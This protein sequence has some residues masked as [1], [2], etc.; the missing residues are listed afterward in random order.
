MTDQLTADQATFPVDS[1]RDAAPHLRRP[2]ARSAVKFKIVGGNTVAAF[3]DA[4]LV[5]ERL[6]LVVPHLWFDEYETVPGGLLCKLT[7]DGISRIDIGTGYANNA[8]GLRSDSFKRAAVKF[9][10]GVSLY[11]IP[12]VAIDSQYTTK[13]G[14]STLITGAG[15]KHLRDRYEGWLENFG[16]KNF[17]DVLDHGDSEDAAGDVEAEEGALAE[18]DAPAEDPPLDTGEALALVARAEELAKTVPAKTLPPAAFKRQLASA[19]PSIESLELLVSSLE[20][21]Q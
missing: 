13:Q 18:P 12:S 20:E 15:M 11:A 17:G 6:N 4:R 14:K 3:I 19:R 1:Y 5:I 9:G 16:V 8:K 10:V 21:L 2:F 7:V